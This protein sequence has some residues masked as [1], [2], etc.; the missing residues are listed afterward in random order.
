M[1]EELGSYDVMFSRHAEWP[2]ITS[3]MYCS[4]QGWSLGGS[5]L[6]LCIGKGQM[7]VFVFSFHSL[8]VMICSPKYKQKKT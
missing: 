6:N 5:G 2:S 7:T 8:I 4:E 3:V 1:F